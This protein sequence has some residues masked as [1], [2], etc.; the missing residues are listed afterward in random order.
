MENIINYFEKNKDVT[1]TKEDFNELDGMIF[2]RFSY[3]NFEKF[4]SKRKYG[5][6]KF[7]DVINNIFL[8]DGYEKRFRNKSDLKLLDLVRSSLRYKDIYLRNF[9]DIK[10][11][12]N[13]KQ[14]AAVTF[15]NKDKNNKFLIVSF[16]GTDG[17]V[18]G[19]KEDFN[20]AYL[21]K[22]P[23]QEESFK[24]LDKALNF[25]RFKR[26]Y[27]VGHSKGGN[28][29]IYSSSMLNKKKS[30]LIKY[31]YA[32][33]SPGFNKEFYSNSNFYS[34][35]N[36]IKF[37][38]P[39]CSVIGRL[40]IGNYDVNI[41][42]SAKQ[43]LYQ[44]DV[45][46]WKIEGKSLVKLEKFNFL[47][48]KIEALVT[49][50][51]NSLNGEEKKEF[52]EELF[53]IVENF[54]KDDVIMMDKGITNFFLKIKK[55]VKDSDEKTKNI[56]DKLFKNKSK[57]KDVKQIEKVDFEVLDEEEFYK[58]DENDYKKLTHK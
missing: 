32:Y 47:S 20:M 56:F 36:K 33:D 14:F 22:I 18:T 51:M 3:I 26:V 43:V 31:I 57:N 44:H 54:S 24:Y 6:I 8:E 28:L 35:K 37:Y 27:V 46:N 7:I 34:I 52:V 38:A 15:F 48:N 23:S 50:R 40:L 49:D 45:Y 1:F 42:D 11:K 12:E 16:K 25:T 30:S 21:E 55:V 19:W 5:N 13:T 53:K 2:A 58:E 17:S 10:L 4:V 39:V 9:V 29:A 41:V